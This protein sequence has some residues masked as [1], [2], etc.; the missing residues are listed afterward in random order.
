MTGM[1]MVILHLCKITDGLFGKIS[2]L[3]VLQYVNF[4]N[5]RPI[6]RINMH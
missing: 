3:T 2:P 1:L 4:I 6:G 5:N